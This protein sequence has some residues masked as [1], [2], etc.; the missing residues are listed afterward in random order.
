[1]VKT[2]KQSIALSTFPDSWKHAT[3]TPIPKAG[4]L[5]LVTNWRPI[6]ILP[7]IEKLMEKLCNKILV[8]YLELQGILC[9]EQFGFRKNRSTS[10]AI[11][12]YVKHLTDNINKKRLTGSMY[13][14]FARA[15]D[16]INHPRLVEKLFDM[17]V[18]GKLVVWIEDYLNNGTIRT[19]LNN[20]VSNAGELLCGVPQGS[21]VG[22][23]LFLCYIND[24]A[25]AMRDV[26][27]GIFLYADDAVI[28]HSGTNENQIMNVLEQ[29]FQRTITWCSRNY[30]NINVDKTKFCIY[31]TRSSV[32]KVECQRIT[33]NNQTITRCQQYNYLG[34][35]LDEYLNLS[36]NFNK[37]F[38]KYSCKIFQFGKIK[39][40]ITVDTRILVYKQT[41]LP[42][43]EYVSYMLCLNPRLE[44]DKLQ[45]LQNC[46]LRMCLNI[47]NPREMS[48][49]MLH[50]TACVS[51]WVTRTYSKTDR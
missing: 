15:I 7:L 5:S 28:Y 32:K 47:N 24:L 51:E 42:L 37:I 4:D 11:F 2:L 8:D 41:I 19:K 43:V 21:I 39:K 1:M 46:C 30:I 44:V 33:H 26:G 12:N 34:V 36:A 50:S 9:D 16:S 40:Y 49:A 17:G 22:P 18:P 13:I 6:S 48:V 31:G 20:N 35:P 27:A 10:L 23:T 25:L 45:N 3:V 14:D 29:A 38:K